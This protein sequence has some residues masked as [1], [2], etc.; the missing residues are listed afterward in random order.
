MLDDVRDANALKVKVQVSGKPG[1]STRSARAYL[2][3][4]LTSLS[5]QIQR[6]SDEGE[7]VLFGSIGNGLLVAAEVVELAA[8]EIVGNID[9]Y[10][11]RFPQLL[12][13]KQASLIN[14]LSGEFPAQVVEKALQDLVGGEIVTEKGYLRRADHQI[15]LDENLEV[16]SGQI[17]RLLING[18]FNP[19]TLKSL[20]KDL[21]LSDAELNAALD[22]MQQQERIVRM[23]DGS[24]WAM[25]KVR[26]AWG[27]LRLLSGGGQGRTMAELREALECPRRF[28]VKFVEYLDREGL[29]ERREDLR[30]PGSQ[31]DR[32]LLFEE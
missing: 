12:G 1:L 22:V 24:P 15:R 11:R 5:A 32:K 29:T 2:N 30:F 21:K 25:Q 16:L 31:F 8:K 6:L 7:V 26:E 9:G 10:H 13:I 17:E 19:P 14:E 23:A 27:I 4:P 28:V 3:A 20:Q 18:G